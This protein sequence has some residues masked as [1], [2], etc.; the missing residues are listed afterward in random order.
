LVIPDQSLS[1]YEDA[2]VCWKSEMAKE[3]KNALIL[4]AAKFDFPIHKPYCQLTENEKRTLWYGN[5]YFGG[6][7]QYFEFIESQIY[8]IQN[9]VLLARYRGVTICP[10]CNGTRLKKEAN[11]VKIFT[12]NLTS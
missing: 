12:K 5:E 7:Y 8:K 11:Y 6:I 1:I 9:R 3:W 10:E 2:V 4:N